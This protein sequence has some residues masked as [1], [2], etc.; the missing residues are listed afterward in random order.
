MQRRMLSSNPVWTIRSVWLHIVSPSLDERVCVAA[1]LAYPDL[2]LNQQENLKVNHLTRRTQRPPSPSLSRLCLSRLLS[3]LRPENCY[4]CA[5]VTC[6]P[7]GWQTACAPPPPSAYL[8]PPLPRA[9]LPP[10]PMWIRKSASAS[11]LPRESK[12]ISCILLTI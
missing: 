10:S 1:Y 5:S 12:R 9:A 11:T 3:A 2:S 4:C 6:L 7:W 8:P